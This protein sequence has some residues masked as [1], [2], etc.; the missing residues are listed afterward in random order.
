M[1]SI[2]E[3]TRF[4]HEDDTNTIDFLLFWSSNQSHFLKFL[5]RQDFVQDKLDPRRFLKMVDET[6]NWCIPRIVSS[7]TNRMTINL[8][9]HY[10]RGSRGTAHAAKSLRWSV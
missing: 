8:N 6:P 9:K 7:I 3:C 10:K 4:P 1:S 5:W 2:S